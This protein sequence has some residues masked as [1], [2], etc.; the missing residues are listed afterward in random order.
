MKTQLIRLVAALL[1][2]SLVM[3][4]HEL[5]KAMIYKRLNNS[6]N[7][8]KS[9]H[10]V[11]RIHHYIDPIGLILCVTSQAGFSK[12]YMYRIK[13][14]KT[15]FILGIVGFLS[16]A[17]VFMVS[18]VLLKFAIG[19]ETSSSYLESSG[20]L[21]YFFQC[22]LIYIALISISMLLVNL[23]P[24]S[25]FDMGLCIAGKSPT[26]YFTIIRNDYFIKM[27]LVLVIMFRFITS[28]GTIIMSSFL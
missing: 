20:L 17:I 21:E 19:I 13:D 9:K 10:N 6:S 11:Y 12:P 4:L 14:K 27:L 1:A 22:T 18:M 25:T 28:V 26:K 24:I 15:N 2:G 5:P 7:G 16:L 8:K 3:I 23:F